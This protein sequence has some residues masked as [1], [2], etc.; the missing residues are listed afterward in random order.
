[1]A[2]EILEGRTEASIPLDA[3][4]QPDGEDAIPRLILALSRATFSCVADEVDGFDCQLPM[5]CRWCTRVI[6]SGV[7]WEPDALTGHVRF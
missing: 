1:M 7:G 2:D 3:S 4:S 6:V 5:N